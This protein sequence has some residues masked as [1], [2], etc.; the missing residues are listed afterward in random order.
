MRTRLLPW[1]GLAF[2]AA[3]LLAAAVLPRLFG[4]VT[5]A[6]DRAEA[7]REDIPPL[8]AYTDLGLVGG[9]TLAAVVVAAALAALT[10]RLGFVVAERTTWRRLQVLSYGAGLVW[11]LALALTDGP[12]GLTEPLAYPSEYL[13]TARAV[14]D[15]PALLDGYVDRI[16][17]DSEDN[18]PA[19]VAGHPPA[20]VL[21]FVALDRLGLGGD[22]AVALVVVLIGATIPLLVQSTLRTLGA[23]SAARAAAPFLAVS[24]AAL[25][26]AVSAD[27]VFTAVG[28]A[29][30]AALARSAVL[31]R[32][33]V[34]LRGDAPARD[35]VGRAGGVGWV[36]WGVLAGLLCGL[37][38]M[39]SYGF[40]LLAVVA[41]AV[42]VVARSWRPVLAVVPAALAVVAVFAVLGFAWWEAYPVLRE[43]YWDGIASDRPA[44]YWI[45]G[46]LAALTVTTGPLLWAGLATIAGE[47]R[48]PRSL[49]AGTRVVVM[50]VAGACLATLAA[51]VSLMSKAEVERIWLI[52]VPWLLV[53]TA[54][55]RPAWR[56]PGLA[57]QATFAIVVELLLNTSW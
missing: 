1:L 5:R 14:D 36:G 42:L 50:L 25:Y 26:V 20:A 40:G 55:L 48:H 39:L 8:H 37:G 46:N 34:A 27:A 11:L 49:A 44:S 45:W 54:L 28:A 12:E 38:V 29:G 16:P 7:G 13:E 18:W 52:F 9:W 47:L 15:V 43:R 10:C 24:P 23:E 17:L 2:A 51:D 57:L 3:L 22:L 33:A 35:G 32:P 30:M 19:H 56:A 6:G 53:S 4:W 41:L 31:A 21:F